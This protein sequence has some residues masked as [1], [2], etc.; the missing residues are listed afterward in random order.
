MPCN[1]VVRIEAKAGVFEYI[2]P[3]Y[4]LK[5]GHSTTGGPRWSSIGKGD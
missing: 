5:R 2:Q 4:I 1:R 3:F